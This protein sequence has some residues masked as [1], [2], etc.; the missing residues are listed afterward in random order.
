MAK[1]FA[2]IILIIFICYNSIETFSQNNK[3]TKRADIKYESGEYY[4][5]I[6]I[7]ER[8]LKKKSKKLSKEQ[9]SEIC[10]RIAECYNY[11]NEPKKAASNYTKAIKQGYTLPVAYLHLA[12]VLKMDE[13]FDEA[14][15]EYQ[16]YKSLVPGDTIGDTGIRS[17]QLAIEWIKNPTRYEVQPFKELN[18]KYSDFCPCFD[19]RKEYQDVYF[20]STRE[21]IH[22]KQISS[23]S[24]QYFS[25]IFFTS[26]D[27]KGKWSKPEPLDSLVNSIY[28][29]GSPC[30][31]QKANVMYFTRCR[32]EKTKH[33]G[34][35]IYV[36]RKTGGYWGEASK[37][38]IIPNNENDS[39]SIAHPSISADEK[40]LYF[41]SNMKGG[42]GRND[43][44][45]VE[46]KDKGWG[47][48]V[49][50]GPEINS[51][52]DEMYPFIRDDGVLF[53]S[54]DRYPTMGGLDIFKAVKDTSN[55][56]VVENMKY[57]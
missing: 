21:G 40:T 48:P 35:Q 31:N 9:K 18:T 54:S 52:Y 20:T 36:A 14:I 33:I 29:D 53:F 32:K 51:E 4:R 12:E 55:K 10:F 57:P 28:D 7:Y 49:N 50:L 19:S 25:D 45:K 17:C 38:V 30:L 15:V 46:K 34:C 27:K 26:I 44:W 39:I 2:I 47:E 5:A 23:I 56:W 6:K 24:G 43:I 13:R 3:Y 11:I 22:D 41:V 37:E 1:Y 16:N 8:V 42:L